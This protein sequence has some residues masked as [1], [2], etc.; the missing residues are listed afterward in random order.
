VGG[1]SRGAGSTH[2]VER[3]VGVPCILPPA[4][5]IPDQGVPVCLERDA[6]GDHAGKGPCAGEY[7]DGKGDS[8]GVVV[9][10]ACSGKD[11]PI[12]E[13]NGDLGEAASPQVDNEAEELDLCVQV[14]DALGSQVCSG[15]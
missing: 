4:P 6:D 12:E 2:Q 3:V 9:D 7:D 8:V 15:H 14:R 10:C 1:G 5:G 13:E 11:V